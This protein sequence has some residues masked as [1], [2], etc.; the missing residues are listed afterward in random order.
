MSV[1]IL[2]V[3]DLKTMRVLSRGLIDKQ[4][5]MTVVAE[6]QNGCTALEL[7]ARFRPDVVVMDIMMPGMNGIDATRRIVEEFPGTKVI[8]L[9]MH[10]DRQF[11]TAMFRA[12]A[13]GYLLKD[14]I[15][16]E[17]ARAIRTVVDKQ[18][19]LCSE[20]DG[21]VVEDNRK[22]IFRKNSCSPAYC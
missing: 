15:F 4:P 14:H 5:G 3:D 18:I 9:S 7:T 10:S 2:L 17:L 16:E 19:F 1:K 21:T 13:S 6:A 12:G 8:A 11:V 20:L 22:N